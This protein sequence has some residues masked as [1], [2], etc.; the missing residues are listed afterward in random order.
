MEIL[1]MPKAEK[2][3][4]DSV[5]NGKATTGKGRR[6]SHKLDGSSGILCSGLRTIMDDGTKRIKMKQWKTR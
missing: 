5:Q 4:Y 1:L 3:F 6:A 2:D